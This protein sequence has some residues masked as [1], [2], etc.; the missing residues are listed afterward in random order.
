MCGEGVERGPSVLTAVTRGVHVDLVVAAQR[1]Q[2][3]TGLGKLS[4]PGMCLVR[5]VQP[6]TVM[7]SLMS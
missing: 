2:R 6:P 7:T 1:L 5:N 3:T 4:E